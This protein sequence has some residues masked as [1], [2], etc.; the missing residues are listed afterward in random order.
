MSDNNYR[1]YADVS[2]VS[3]VAESIMP[4]TIDSRYDDVLK[5]SNVKGAMIHQCTISAGGKNRE[6]G[7]DINRYCKDI[8]ILESTV[9]SGRRYAIT[10]KGG[11]KNIYLSDV[12]I[13]GP[14]GS[15]N[16][17]IDIGNYSDSTIW[18]TEDIALSGVY[19]TDG[20]PVHV[21]IGFAKNVTFNNMKVKKLFWQSLGLKAYVLFKW[22]M[23]KV[24][25]WK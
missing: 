23:V 2:G 9:Q 3:V 8:D 15:E 13:Y 22:A 14:R 7:I 25:A 1:S 24:G 4:P 10:I 19:R 17:D 6:D 12:Q 20:K 18:G 5:L 21:R 11:S 16:V